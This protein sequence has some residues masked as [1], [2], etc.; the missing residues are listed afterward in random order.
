MKRLFPIFAICIAIA[1]CLSL[2][3]AAKADD[4]S[5]SSDT[6]RATNYSSRDDNGK[7][8]EIA[9]AAELGLLAYEVNQGE[10]FDGYTIVLKNDID[11]SGH[12][13][14]PIAHF[15]SSYINSS[16]PAFRGSF[17]GNGYTISNMKIQI[18]SVSDDN[19]AFGLFGAVVCGSVRNLS[20]TN[21][22]VEIDNSGEDI[23][24]GVAAGFFAGSEVANITVTNSTITASGASVVNV[25]GVSG[26]VYNSGTWDTS[27]LENVFASNITLSAVTSQGKHRGGITGFANESYAEFNNCYVKD[28]RFAETAVQ[29]KTDASGDI[30]GY[31]NLPVLNYCYYN[32]ATAVGVNGPSLPQISDISRESQGKLETPVTINGEIY[33]TLVGALNAW[34]DNNSGSGAFHAWDCVDLG[35][36]HDLEVICLDASSHELRCKNCSY[37]AE[38]GHK[39]ILQ[40]QKDASCTDDG[41]SG[42]EVCS[43]CNE[44]LKQGEVIKK[45]EHQYV[46]GKCTVCGAADPEYKKPGVTEASTDKSANATNEESKESVSVPRT[47]DE[48]PVALWVGILAAACVLVVGVCIYRKKNRHE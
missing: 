45:L 47:G 18:S 26:C 41:Y 10:Q 35:L 3:I 17:D 44:V 37:S 42:D 8:I 1:G 28:V 25:G 15:T 4:T 36:E 21:A 7:K 31:G 6:V 9:S 5:W 46:N 20:L 16:V 39:A 27:S 32:G 13:W 33:D 22:V 14:D 48:A 40:N 11:L 38:E 2:H 24:A 23:C 12:N 30:M 43:I 19:Q 34:V 29:D